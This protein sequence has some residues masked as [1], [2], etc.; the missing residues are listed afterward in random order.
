MSVVD[1]PHHLLSLDDWAELPETPE[2]QVEVVEGVLLVSPRPLWFHQR[3]VT[4]LGYL[5]DARL[6]AE[7][8]AFSEVEVVIHESPL[9]VR[10]PDVVVA[11]SKLVDAETARL[12]AENV[13][14]VIEV[15]S[16]GTRRTDRV[17]KFSEYSEVGIEH[18]WIVDLDDPVSMIT[19]RLVEGEY[20][21]FGEHSGAAELDFEG[22]PITIDLNAL[23]TPRAQRL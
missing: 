2:F 21:N 1:W 7:F 3:A 16:E 18:Y 23:T 19:Y 14:L 12:G 17:M 15:L 20:E 8:G 11:P 4:R 22:T 13:R 10:V 6:P 5:L 9:T